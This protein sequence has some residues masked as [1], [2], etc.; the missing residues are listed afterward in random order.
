MATITKKDG[1]RDSAA[2][3]TREDTAMDIAQ[4]AVSANRER[5]ERWLIAQVNAARANPAG[6]VSVVM[7]VGPDLA[8]VLLDRNPANRWINRGSVMQ[9]VKDIQEGRWCFNGEPIIV[10]SDG[11]LNDGQNRCQAIA[12]A[13]ITVPVLMVIGVERDSRMSLG[14]GTA[15]TPGHY[16]HMMGFSNATSFAR[17]LRV[18]FMMV[19]HGVVY[20]DKRYSPT[21]AE[22][23]DFVPEAPGLEDSIARYSTGYA[24]TSRGMM[25]A[26]HWLFS[27]KNPDDANTYCD[28]I[29]YGLGLQDRDPAL[30]VRRRLLEVKTTA[31]LRLNDNALAELIIRG[32]NA[33]REGRRVKA[34]PVLGKIPRII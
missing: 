11:L 19:R 1:A 26:L 15:R 6:I 23:T 7:N 12:E 25:A 34:M 28:A 27:Q 2:L 4:P 32:W 10:S 20:R 21:K 9:I 3:L 29:W 5:A 22:L 18:V 17:A 30:V 24:P 14:Q 8:A 31:G 16:M 33:Y 13:G